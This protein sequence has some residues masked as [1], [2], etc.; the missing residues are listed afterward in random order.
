MKDEFFC[1]N[2]QRPPDGHVC[3][4]FGFCYKSQTRICEAGSTKKRINMI[5]LMMDPSQKKAV[6]AI[7]GRKG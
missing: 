5:Y 4:W 2:F 3:G 7:V 1:P 6:N